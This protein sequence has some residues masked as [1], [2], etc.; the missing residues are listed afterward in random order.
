MRYVTNAVSV[1]SITQRLERLTDHEE[2]CGF[3]PGLGLRNWFSE[4]NPLTAKIDWR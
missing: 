4:V 1:V 3:D 2:C